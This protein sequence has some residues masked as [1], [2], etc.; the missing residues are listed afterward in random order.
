MKVLECN[1]CHHLFKANVDHFTYYSKD[2][3]HNFCEEC[4]DKI[5]HIIHRG[6]LKMMEED[7]EVERMVNKIRKV[8]QLT[9]Q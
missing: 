5:W 8:Q 6:V 2:G 9:S 4:S 1:C 7:E 3:N